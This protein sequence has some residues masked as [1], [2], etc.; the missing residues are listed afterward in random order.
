MTRIIIG[1]LVSHDMSSLVDK[2]GKGFV[3][4]VIYEITKTK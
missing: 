4:F 1:M 2:K 3:K